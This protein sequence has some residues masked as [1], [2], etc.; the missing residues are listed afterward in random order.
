ML[1][2]NRI[3][4]ECLH[5]CWWKWKW[6]RQKER[7]GCDTFHGQNFAVTNYNLYMGAVDMFEKYQSYVQV[8]L[9]SRKY[10]HPLFWFI[11]EAALINA[12]LLYKSSCELALLPLEYSLFTFRKSIALALASEWERMGCRQKTC[13]LSPTKQMQSSSQTRSHLKKLSVN[14][15]TRF[16]AADGHISFL[17]TIPLWTDSKVKLH[18]M[19]C[20]QCKK[21]RTTYCWREFDDK[22]LCRGLCFANYH[23]QEV[24]LGS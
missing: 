23:S 3:S 24:N 21:E 1:L 19:H 10:W 8:E 13:K 15:G 18:Q 7:D 16:T 14:L 20:Q 12:W 6:W 22:P 17:A 5:L 11:I 4:L 2:S 9:R